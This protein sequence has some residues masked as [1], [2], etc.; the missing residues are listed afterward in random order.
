MLEWKNGGFTSGLM[1]ELDN[2]NDS[3]NERMWC[4]SPITSKTSLAIWWM[5]PKSLEVVL[6]NQLEKSH[7][8]L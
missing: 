2:L 1:D 6:A 7:I 5:S 8:L 3:H 4:F